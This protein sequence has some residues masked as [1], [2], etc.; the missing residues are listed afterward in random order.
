MRMEAA[1]E[2]PLGTQVA[3]GCL[4]AGLA[5]DLTAIA[6]VR[7][8]A[9]TGEPSSHTTSMAPRIIIHTPD[10]EARVRTAAGK[11][12]F[13][14]EPPVTNVVQG[15]VAARPVDVDVA[16][17]QLVGTVLQGRDSGFVIVDLPDAGMK[18]VRI[19][20]MAGSLRLRSVA[21]GAAQ[22]DDARGVHVVRD[23]S[24]KRSVV[25]ET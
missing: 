24:P 19:G 4:L 16:R 13:D 25:Q 14:M 11:S 22:F 18:V 21:V 2:W 10:D 17:P 23:R 3:A 12:P 7:H 1:R 5:L 6:R 20:E 9:D 15:L 8:M